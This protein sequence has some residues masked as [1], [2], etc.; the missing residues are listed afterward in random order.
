M[1]YS[2]TTNEE[3]EQ[4][5]GQKDGEAI[6]EL[7]ERCMYGTNG[8][9]K[10]LTRAYQL[11]HK[12]EKLGLK[13]AYLGLAKM[14]EKGIYF[15]KN[16]DLANEYHQKA[17]GKM[18]QEQEPEKKEMTNGTNPPVINTAEIRTK[19]EN[20]KAARRQ[21]NFAWARA[22]CNEALKMLDR[23][24]AGT[25]SCCGSEDPDVLEIDAYW[26]LAY[27]AFNEQQLP[28]MEKYLSKEGVQALHPWGAYIAAVA[29]RNFQQ[30]DSVL[31]QDLQTLL[32]V[33]EN[34]NLSMDEKGDVAM[35]IAE[36]ILCGYGK[37]TGCTVRTAYD[38]YERA[39]NCGNQYAKEQLPKFRTSP[40]GE[41]IFTE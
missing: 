39:A 4:L 37:S 34:Q 38:Y 13:R 8:C 29:H 17:E 24:K 7:G 23:I 25:V 2:N 9:A 33:S 41:M 27:I 11:F 6:C 16:D 31:E 5:A 1:D 10:N 15:A 12:G 26:L 22:E 35:M 32:M 14:Y 20:A 30:P 21:E 3:L 19:I 36:L 40:V 18:K 28:E